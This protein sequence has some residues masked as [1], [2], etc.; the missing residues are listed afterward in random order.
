M[1]KKSIIIIC[2][3]L[4]VVGLGL[5]APLL[6]ESE[7]I[8]TTLLGR[9]SRDFKLVIATKSVTFKWLPTPRII[10]SGVTLENDLL[11]V[12]VPRA[13]LTASVLSL[14]SKEAQIGV[15]QLTG[16]H[17]HLKSWP[18][19]PEKTDPGSQP[20]S[21][22]F[23]R[24]P[25]VRFLVDDGSFTMAEGIKLPFFKPF[26]TI[27]IF[28]G[29]QADL[30]TSPERIGFNISTSAPF[31]Q[32]LSLQGAYQPRQGSYTFD[33]GLEQFELQKVILALADNRIIPTES[34]INLAVHVEG[35]GKDDLNLGIKGESPSF[36]IRLGKTPQLIACGAVDLGLTIKGRDIACNIK[37]FEMK[38]PGFRIAGLIEHRLPKTGQKTSE[39]APAPVW[40]LNLKA[41]DLDVTAIREAVLN[42]LGDDPITK[43]V[44]GIVLAGKASKATYD[45]EGTVADFADIDRM[46][47]TVDVDTATIH[48]PEAELHLTNA[49]GP[50]RIEKGIL[51]GRGLSAQLAE[52]SGKNCLLMVGLG[53]KHHD[54]RLELDLDADLAAL[55]PVLKRLVR[56]SVFQEELHHFKKINGRAI[57][58]LKI[59]DTF[60]DIKVEVVA[61]NIKAS[62]AYDRFSVPLTI[63]N[64]EF[65]LYPAKIAWKNIKAVI[66]PH[67]ISQ[68]DGSVSWEKE[69]ILDIT[70]LN[71]VAD[72]AA[73][74]AELT[75]SGRVNH[76]GSIVR[77]GWL[78]NSSTLVPEAVFK[79]INIAHGPLEITN[80]HIKGNALFP[81]QWEY[82]MSVALNDFKWASPLLPGAITTEHALLDISQSQINLVESRSWFL[83]QLFEVNGQFRHQR[84]ENWQGMINLSGAVQERAA[85]WIRSK[86]W[87]PEAYFPRIPCTLKGLKVA[88]DP[89]AIAITGAVIA[90]AGGNSSVSISLD[91][92]YGSDELVVKKIRFL[93]PGEQGTMTLHLRE[94]PEPGFIFTWQGNVSSDTVNALLEKN[95][96]LSGNLKGAFS[97]NGEYDKSKPLFAGQL[98]AENLSYIFGMD[99]KPFLVRRVQLKSEQNR[100]MLN[101]LTLSGQDQVMSIKGGLTPRPNALDIRLDVSSNRLNWTTV[102]MLLKKFDRLAGQWSPEKVLPEKQK[103][104]QQ[105]GGV[106]NFAMQ[107]FTVDQAPANR[108]DNPGRVDLIFSPIH[109]KITIKSKELIT[110]EITDAALCGIKGKGVFHSDDSLGPRSISFRTDSE[111]PLQFQDVLSCLQVKQNLLEG[112]LVVDAHLQGNSKQ[113]QSGQASLHA[114]KGYIRRFTLLSKIFSIVNLTDLFSATGLSDLGSKHKVKRYQ[115]KITEVKELKPD[116]V[117]DTI[118]SFKLGEK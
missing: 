9:L 6:L 28:T 90:G 24:L 22:D 37:T 30:K 50:I 65:Y 38:D 99:L 29:L 42:L 25:R 74:L 68:S 16:P 64:G 108:L 78:I 33:I 115:I 40:R 10:L 12:Q 112:S 89:K 117:T 54:F 86:K 113:W 58:T 98:A 83:E 109:G 2:S 80:T 31:A 107:S 55:P 73:L 100:I 76:P 35:S 23:T 51:S 106:I 56:Q 7:K 32:E 46:T 88:W 70:R 79:V 114:T 26:G 96:L 66:G 63:E 93:A 34:K 111:N 45:F 5:C 62:A 1:K 13:V 84:M 27:G 91:L 72:G 18:S 60:K 102:D 4:L 105:L 15:L 104:P 101:E 116:E 71:G 92:V 43:I 21:L 17:I 11:A 69:T 97:I 36:Q 110:T 87:I 77:P 19:A 49:S 41:A 82:G 61:K 52:S 57:A 14:F 75:N 53:E 48:V 103:E 118:I 39:P 81:E 95:A 94:K 20:A 8:Q 67:K 59:G 47:L 3:L 44:C 85:S